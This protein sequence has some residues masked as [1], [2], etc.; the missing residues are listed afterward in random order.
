VSGR[1]GSFGSAVLKLSRRHA[2]PRQALSLRETSLGLAWTWGKASG[3]GWGF[4]MGESQSRNSCMHLWVRLVGFCQ[5]VRSTSASFRWGFRRFL[6]WRPVVV[7]PPQCDFGGM[8]SRCLLSRYTTPRWPK[9]REL[10]SDAQST[11]GRQ[12]KSVVE[13]I[14]EHFG[15][16]AFQNYSDSF[17]GPFMPP[18]SHCGG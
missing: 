14:L 4:Q 13:F 16:F 2:G 6:A 7:K 5:P 18:Q 8:K 12:F 17:A 15:E 3:P 11:R 9:N 10:D 1:W